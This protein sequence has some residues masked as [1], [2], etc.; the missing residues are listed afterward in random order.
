[1]PGKTDEVQVYYFAPDVLAKFEN[2]SDAKIIR[3]LP[4][5]FLSFPFP[6]FLI[7]RL[8]IIPEIDSIFVSAHLS[9]HRDA[10]VRSDTSQHARSYRTPVLSGISF[11]DTRIS[12]IRH[13][14][15]AK[16]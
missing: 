11:N 7:L 14:L 8:Y 1:M 16:D 2:K 15:A 13:V 5:S 3:V 9:V 6:F 12:P 4:V 10:F